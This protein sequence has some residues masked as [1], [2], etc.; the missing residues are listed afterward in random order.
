DAE[1]PRRSTRLNRR[2][3]WRPA[4]GTRR[5]VLLELAPLRQRIRH[6][7]RGIPRT[8]DEPVPPERVADLERASATRAHPDPEG[9]VVL[10]TLGIDAVKVRAHPAEGDLHPGDLAGPAEELRHR[11][12]E[13]RGRERVGRRTG[14]RVVDAL[15]PASAAGAP[16]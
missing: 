1:R 12:H 10:G 4:D 11:F 15:N 14:G 9:L 8:T 5:L 7:A 2:Y 13:A 6:P 16:C 3:Y